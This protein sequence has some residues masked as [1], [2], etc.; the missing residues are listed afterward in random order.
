MRKRGSRFLIAAKRSQVHQSTTAA[1][2]LVLASLAGN[3]QRRVEG[4]G[5][6]FARNGWARGM[7][8][9]GCALRAGWVAQT[10]KLAEAMNMRHQPYSAFRHS[11]WLTLMLG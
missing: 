6:E 11:L 4:V 7:S 9:I 8:D 3:T 1:V 5:F 2:Q 10:V